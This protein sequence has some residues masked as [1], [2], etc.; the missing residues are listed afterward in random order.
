MAKHTIFRSDKM[1][2]TYNAASLVN[3]LL[4]EDMDNGCIV[5]IGDLA[6]GEREAYEGDKPAVSDALGE[7]A[8]IAAP[9]VMYDS[10]LKDLADF[11]NEAGAIVRG[12][13]FHNGDEFS[14]TADGFTGSPAVGNVVEVAAAYKLKTA[15]SATGGSTQIG[16]I[17]AKEGDYYVV[18]VQG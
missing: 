12:Y 6:D 8:L 11:Y 4:A 7:L 9:E 18:R 14:L 5:K 2:G 13:R 16:K 1:H 10:R 15:A 3:I 17:I